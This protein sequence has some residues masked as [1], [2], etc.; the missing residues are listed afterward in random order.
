MKKILLV[1]LMSLILSVHTS[2]LSESLS[3]ISE[4]DDVDVWATFEIVKEEM[5]KRG[6]DIDSDSSLDIDSMTDFELIE[7]QQKVQE[8]IFEYDEY[9]KF[10]LYPGVYV[11]GEDIDEGN[12]VVNVLDYRDDQAVT[13]TF[14]TVWPDK[15]KYG[16][17]YTADM[18]TTQRFD[19]DK[20]DP[21]IQL[22]LKNGMYMELH[23][24]VFQFIK[25]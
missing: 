3:D 14:L 12:Y 18:V 22:N 16:S 21:T 11:V 6:L 15:D 2:S 20:D 5:E 23:F 10:A 24:S 17:F 7:L 25:R 19:K 9:A 4:W 1:L 8:K 13:K